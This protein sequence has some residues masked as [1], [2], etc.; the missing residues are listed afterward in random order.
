VASPTNR[1]GFQPTWRRPEATLPCQRRRLP[2]CLC[3]RGPVRPRVNPRQSP[4]QS[5]ECRATTTPPVRLL[6]PFLSTRLQSPRTQPPR[7]KGAVA[8]PGADFP[9]PDSNQL[10]IST[11]SNRSV[12]AFDD[13]AIEQRRGEATRRSTE[14]GPP[15]QDARRAFPLNLAVPRLL[16]FS[17]PSRP[18][19]LQPQGPRERSLRSL[20]DA[21]LARG[22]GVSRGAE[23]LAEARARN[24]PPSVRRRRD[25]GGRRP[26]EF[27]QLSFRFSAFPGHHAM[28][29]RSSQ[30]SI[31]SSLSCYIF[32]GLLLDLVR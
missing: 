4:K 10:S 17:R 24:T 14:K 26:G 28:V 2:T 13:C 11:G 21:A 1:C 29:Q 32:F 3:P 27:R 18:L 9:F 23:G 15:L 8:L 30:R 12:L 5:A 31:R 6:L 20:S 22:G 25:G 7:D 19:Q 16:S